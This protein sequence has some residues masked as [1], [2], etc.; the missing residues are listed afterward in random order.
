MKDVKD[1]VAHA[2]RAFGALCKQVFH[3][4]DLSRKTKRMVYCAAILDVLF[5]GVET[6]ANKRSA[7]S[8][9]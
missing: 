9:D 3:D 2:S 8:I 6:W 7:H 1:E 5:Y 4:D